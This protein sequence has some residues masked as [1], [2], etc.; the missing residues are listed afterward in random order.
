MRRHPLLPGLLCACLAASWAM[1]AAAR[2]THPDHAHRGPKPAAAAR[3]PIVVELF[4]AQGC[5]SCGKANAMVARL[6]DQPGLTPLTWSVDYWDYLGWKDTFAQPE[7]AQR[8]RAYDKRFGVNDVY[9]PQIIVD[10]LGQTTGGDPAAVDELIRRAL[11]A[12]IARPA[13]E[14]RADGA[15]AIGSG[16]RP[17]GGAEVWLIRFDPRERDV[18]V[19]EGDN[20][21]STVPARNVVRQLVR[22]GGWSGRPT[23]FTLPAAPEDGLTT[24]VVVQGDDGGRVLGALQQAPAPQAG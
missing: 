2:G 3:M 17:R 15:V 16:T 11:R 1:P 10:G 5:V 4:T 14:W 9:T 21:G 20:R 13:M 23:K 18:A 7:F 19:K 6:A 22:L 8:Q 24:L 12:P